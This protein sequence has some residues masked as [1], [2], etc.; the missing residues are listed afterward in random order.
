MLSQLLFDPV[1]LPVSG[2][3][4]IRFDENDLDI[5]V[6]T[7]ALEERIVHLLRV[8]GYPL[9]VRE[10]T[11]GIGSNASQTNRGLRELLA[12][13]DVETIDIAGNVREYA[14]IQR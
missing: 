14:L 2:G 5:R 1:Q 13:G 4:Q 7:G 11:A 8:R 10:I 12:R 3:R 9:T 6:S